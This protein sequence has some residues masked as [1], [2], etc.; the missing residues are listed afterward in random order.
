MASKT[1]FHAPLD[2]V[3]TVLLCPLI[4]TVTCSPEAALPQRG[5]GIDRCN[6][7]LLEKVFVTVTVAQ[8][9][10]DRKTKQNVE[11]IQIDGIV[12]IFIAVI[13]PYQRRLF[14]SHHG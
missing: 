4:V 14:E 7:M 11:I 1:A 8:A 10:D 12:F 13:L 6:T 5:T 2:G 9:E 3:V